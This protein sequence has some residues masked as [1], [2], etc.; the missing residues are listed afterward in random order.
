M[1][2]KDELT[3][4]QCKSIYN[5]PIFLYCCSDNICKEHLSSELSNSSLNKITCPFCS[6]DIDKHGL[7]VNKLIQKLVENELHNFKTD[8]KFKDLISDFRNEIQQVKKI[9][10]DP[11]NFVYDKLSEI[12]RQVDF[13]REYCK[14]CKWKISRRIYSTVRITISYKFLRSITRKKREKFKYTKYRF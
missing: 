12:K 1:N 3:C 2:I 7:N 5:E 10:N 8:P 9:L 6:T 14:F 13:D 11:E 4:K